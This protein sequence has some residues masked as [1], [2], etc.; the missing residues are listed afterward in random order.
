L[1]ADLQ[2]VEDLIELL[3]QR[4]EPHHVVIAILLAEEPVGIRHE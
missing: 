1:F 3:R 4:I 2:A